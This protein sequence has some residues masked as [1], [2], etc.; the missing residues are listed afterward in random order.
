[1]Y[2]LSTNIKIRSC[3][4]Y[5]THDM[6]THDSHLVTTRTKNSSLFAFHMKVWRQLPRANATTKKLYADPA[7]YGRKAT[8]DRDGGLRCHVCSSSHFVTPKAHGQ[9]LPSS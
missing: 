4:R 9:K 7:A 6:F 8:I 1:M 2:F 5:T 3:V